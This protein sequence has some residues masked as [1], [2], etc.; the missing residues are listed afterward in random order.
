[1]FKL[2]LNIT[3]RFPYSARIL[4]IRVAVYGCDLVKAKERVCFLFSLK[5]RSLT[6]EGE[7]NFS[8]KFGI[9]LFE[10]HHI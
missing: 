8:H 1:M 10:N 5:A 7:A 9:R 4:C 6:G 2:W 3:V